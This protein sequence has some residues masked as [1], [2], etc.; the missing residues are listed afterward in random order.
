M[1]ALQLAGYLKDDKKVKATCTSADKEEQFASEHF[2]EGAHSA[3]EQA[4]VVEDAGPST[5]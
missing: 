4:T 5:P 1:P 2:L 3:T